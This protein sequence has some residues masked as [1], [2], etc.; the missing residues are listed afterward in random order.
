MQIIFLSIEVGIIWL[1]NVYTSTVMVFITID[2]AESN[3][4]LK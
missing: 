2:L 1:K 4:K 3:S